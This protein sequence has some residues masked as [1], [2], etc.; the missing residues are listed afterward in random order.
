MIRSSSNYS[1]KSPP[2]KH[3]FSFLFGKLNNKNMAIKEFF[4]EDLQSNLLFN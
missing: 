1:M 2:N 4:P 3:S